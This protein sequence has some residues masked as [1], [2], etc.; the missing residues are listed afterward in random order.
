MELQDKNVECRQLRNDVNELRNELREMKIQMQQ[1]AQQQGYGREY[2]QPPVT[3]Y[4][5]GSQPFGASGGQPFGQAT[6]QPFSNGFGGDRRESSTRGSEAALPP[7]RSLAM[8]TP[9]AF[10]HLTNGGPPA[11]DSFMSSGGP[12]AMAGVQYQNERSYGGGCART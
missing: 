7:L 4:G 10:N 3:S 9:R 8:E 5:P 6:S 11:R 2:Q 12:D 1:Q